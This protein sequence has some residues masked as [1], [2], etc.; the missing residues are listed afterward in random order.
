ML[1]EILILDPYSMVHDLHPLLMLLLQSLQLLLDEVLLV[2][3]LLLSRL[4][5]LQQLPN[6]INLFSTTSF[7]RFLVGLTISIS[8]LVFFFFIRDFWDLEVRIF[9]GGDTELNFVLL[10]DFYFISF[11]I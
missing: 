5:P 2:L 9:F 8:L 11:Y 7:I 1:N 6:Q 3:E 4:R 10:R